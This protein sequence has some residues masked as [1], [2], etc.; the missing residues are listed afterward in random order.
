MKNIFYREWKPAPRARGARTGRAGILL[1]AALLALLADAARGESFEVFMRLEQFTWEEFVDGE[2]LLKEDGP[3]VGIG[4]RGSLQEYERMRLDMRADGFLGRVDYDGRT[5]AGDPIVENTDYLGVRGE[6]DAVVEPGR[7]SA[8]RLHPRFGIGA[9]YWL[10]RLAKGDTDA[11]GYDEGWFMLYARLGADLVWQPA[12]DTRFFIDIARRPAIYNRTWY[13]IRI[14]DEETF[15]LEP[16]RDWTWDVEAGWVTDRYR[17]SVFYETY[18]FKQSDSKLFP[19]L[20]V[21]QP[22]SDG[23]SAGVQMGVM[24]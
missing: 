10:R 2:R 4:L 19:P 6:L 9:R 3:R 15:T 11:G 7:T 24:W 23:R 21:F 22:K 20:E 13:N 16:G 17:F 1:A 8:V 5:F 12:P 18:A 14:Q